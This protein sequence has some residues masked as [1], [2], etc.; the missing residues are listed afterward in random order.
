M[1]DPKPDKATLKKW[2][3]EAKGWV[4]EIGWPSFKS[5]EWLP[6]LVKKSFKSYYDNASA[7]YFRRKYP[8]LKEDAI[9]KKL[10]TVAAKNA[11][12]LGAITGAAISV[13]EIIALV[14]AAPTGGLGLPAQMSAGLAALATEAV[15]LIGIQLKLI[16]EIA[17][18]LGV[19][20]DPDDPE[21]ILVILEF[22]IGGAGIE[23]AGKFTAKMGG[24][25]TRRFVRKKIS[26]STLE[27]LKRWGAKLGIK[28]LQRSIIKYAV[29]IVSALIG[30]T[31]NYLAT[32]KVG[33]IA[34]DHFRKRRS[35]RA[36]KVRRKPRK[37]TKTANPAKKKK[38]RRIGVS[39]QI[40]TDAA[41]VVGS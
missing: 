15:V 31:W 9:V 3:E 21:D 2:Y 11:A 23:A 1:D 22:A 25:A 12:I 24:A 7:A 26:K 34:A 8:G 35:E 32:M 13:D 20:L 18:L 36:K 14:T 39:V 16:A 5:G 30:S 4:T 10:T 17:K 6:I 38:A 28:I 41:H 29:P 33:G 19:R 27:A 37:G 40:L